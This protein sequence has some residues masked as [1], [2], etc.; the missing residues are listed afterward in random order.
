MP[1]PPHGPIPQLP[2]LLMDDIKINRIPIPRRLIKLHQPILPQNLRNITPRKLSI[3]ISWTDLKVERVIL[4]IRSL[5]EL[6]F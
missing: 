6:S 2:P 4:V 5:L 3:D 1:P